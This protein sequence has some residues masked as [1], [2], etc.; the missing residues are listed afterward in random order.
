M[1]EVQTVGHSEVFHKLSGTCH[2][3]V[4]PVGRW[5]R[6][7]WY[8]HQRNGALSGEGLSVAESGS[9]SDE[10]VEC[11]T[12][13]IEDDVEYLRSLDPKEWKDQD[14]YAVLGLKKVRIIAT[15]DDIKRAYRQK[16]LRHHPDKRKAAGEE[17]RADDDYFTC[18]TKAYETLSVA[19]KRRAYDSVDSEF[20][21][22]VPSSNAANK[23]R[24]FEVFSPVIAANARWSVRSNVP[25]LGDV[26]SSRDHVENFYDFWYNFE[27]WREFSYLD[28]E[29]KDKGQDREERRWIEKQN[30][31]ER[32][33]RKKEEMSRLRSLVDA[34]YACDP[35]ILRF[36][37]EDKQKKLDDKKAKQDAVRARKEE[38]ERKRREEEENKLR[39]K[40]QAEEAAR[41][42]QNAAKREKENA[43]RALKREREQLHKYGKQ[44]NYFTGVVPPTAS[45][46]A[47]PTTTAQDE[48]ELVKRMADLDR[49]C[50]LLTTDELDKLNKKM[51][52]VSLD[53]VDEGRTLFDEAV[54]E[55]NRRIDEEKQ[56]H[57]GGGL[58]PGGSAASS[59]GGGVNS[60]S[61]KKGGSNQWSPEELNLLIK[62]VNLFPAG[63]N[64]R[65]EV[66]ANFINQHHGGNRA[67]KEVLAQAKELQSGDFSRSALKEAANKAAYNKFEKESK[68]GPAASEESI[69]SERYET[70]AEQLGINL[71]PWT[72]D[73]QRLLEQALK[74]YPASLSDRWERIAEAI[75]NRSKKEC[76]KRYKELVELVRAKKSAQAAVAPPKK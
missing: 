58:A 42:R 19:S 3:D 31:A 13:E 23:S 10:E 68:A 53:C 64:Q 45:A 65:W 41:A 27:S 9:Q 72:A 59:G 50:E 16:V 36:K 47:S 66:V 25:L 71:T 74:T 56:Q 28:E 33:R 5:F 18:I 4:E 7:W 30:K 20:D 38:E 32:A 73:E 2:T 48:A 17:V 54:D 37:E 11:S 62:A 6:A 49:L 22:D 43:K 67:A 26:N 21:D 60:G 39:I 46:A 14:H 29:E 51:A 61:K 40:R 12:V 52:V 24:F 76:M 34:A 75:P 1:G 70:P 63:T 8:H 15:E 69:P 55:L 44:F 57:L 35:R